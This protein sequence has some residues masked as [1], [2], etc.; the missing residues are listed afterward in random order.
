MRWLR[1]VPLL[2]GITCMGTLVPSR[3]SG[4]E[5]SRASFTMEDRTR[6]LA[7]R[8]AGNLRSR[9]WPRTLQTTEEIRHKL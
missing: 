7:S 1:A 4:V 2:V 6:D 5:I 9:A 3:L 8:I